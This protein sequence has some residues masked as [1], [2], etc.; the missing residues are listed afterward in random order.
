ML[1][2]ASKRAERALVVTIPG[3]LD[4]NAS[5]SSEKQGYTGMANEVQRMENG[6][7]DAKSFLKNLWHIY[8]PLLHSHTLELDWRKPIERFTAKA[9]Y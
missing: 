3:G 8:F 2:L 6:Q 9:V 4:R 1:T 7:N 5:F